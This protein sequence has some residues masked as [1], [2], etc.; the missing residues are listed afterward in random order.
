[1]NS[2]TNITNNDHDEEKPKSSTIILFLSFSILSACILKII[3]S[4]IL[5]NRIPLPFTVA[6]LILGFVVGVIVTEIKSLNNG[7][8][9][10]N[11]I[12][13]NLRN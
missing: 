12:T 5:K 13:L 4:K 3:L 8:I 7:I 11:E 9:K 1:M 6:V 10:G 2:E